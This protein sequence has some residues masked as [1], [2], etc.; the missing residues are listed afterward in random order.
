MDLRSPFFLLR[1]HQGTALLLVLE[2]AA[3]FVLL[4]LAWQ[5]VQDY[6]RAL[7][8][9]SGID[10]AGLLMLPPFG[11]RASPSPEH[12]LEALRTIPGVRAAA[13][14]NQVP[15]AP[16]SWNMGLWSRPAGAGEHVDATVYMGGEG[17]LETL[18][19]PLR[20]GRAFAPSE[21]AT[22]R[23]PPS[24]TGG[25]FLPVI[26]TRG[27]AERLFPPGTALGRDLHGWP[28]TPL[29]IV[30]IV[31]RL[32]QPQG[33]RPLTAAEASLI[34]PLAPLEAA[35]AHFLVRADPAAT[36]AVMARVR[37][38]AVRLA[39][40]SA[41]PE[42]REL[43][44]LRHAYAAGERRWAW[45]VALCAAGWW[46]LAL[47]S[48]GAAGQLWVQHTAGWIGLHRTIGASRR[49]MMRVVR[50]ENFML[51]SLGIAVGVLL[52]IL[53]VPH[54]RPDG[55]AEGAPPLWM[56][57]SALAIWLASQIAVTGAVRRA[58]EVSP[59][60]VTRVPWVRL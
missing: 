41:P 5:A 44:A 55:L 13:V 46:A 47:L 7:T 29:R 20:E 39:R 45:T 48:I 36:G 11:Q 16:N 18:A 25:G 3:G 35:D 23:G 49:Q 22:F 4:C 28:D 54:L 38:Q 37:A 52:A 9:P 31:E 17:L 12:V 15:Y 53:C 58:G 60:H 32:P 27:L 19:A 59:D 51:A 34:L 57:S 30:G 14:V 21:F 8:A 43:A 33:S 56:G 42:A 10:E 50:M 2:I 26:A 24:R 1:K 6:R 40:G